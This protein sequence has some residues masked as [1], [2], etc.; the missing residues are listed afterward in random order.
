MQNKQTSLKIVSKSLQSSYRQFMADF[1]SPAEVV[2]PLL[3]QMP[4][5]QLAL[6]LEKAQTNHYSVMLQMQPS[7]TETRPYNIHGILKT[8]ASGQLVLVNRRQHLTHLI[9]TD[10]IRYLKRAE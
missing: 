7:L 5:F 2:A 3:P 10:Q 9:E 4:T 1:T 6:F 8:L